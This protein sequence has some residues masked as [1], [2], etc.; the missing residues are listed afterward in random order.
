ME[1]DAGT[2]DEPRSQEPESP[3]ETLAA[4][5]HLLWEVELGDTPMAVEFEASGRSA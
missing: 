2:P 1:T 5:L 3:D 4:Q